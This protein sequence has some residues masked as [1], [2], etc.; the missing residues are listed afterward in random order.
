MPPVTVYQAAGRYPDYRDQV[1]IAHDVA[2]KL[3]RATPDMAGHVPAWPYVRRVRAL[4]AAGHDLATIADGLGISLCAVSHMSA[5]KYQQVTIDT[6]ERISAGYETMSALPAGRIT[7]RILAYGWAPPML[8]DDIDDP[9]ESHQAPT[10]RVHVSGPVLAA[11]G[12]LNEAYGHPG[13]AEATGVSRAL[14][15]HFVAGSRLYTSPDTARAILRAAG[16]IQ[17]QAVAA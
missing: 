11:I 1:G 16:R 2:V 4:R 7:T 10:G 3:M 6:A 17:R 15:R 5:A 13:A 12:D 9:D 8:W 14:L